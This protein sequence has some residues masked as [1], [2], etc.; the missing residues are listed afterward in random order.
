M[1]SQR[2]LE[3]FSAVSSTFTNCGPFE[4]LENPGSYL[5]RD[6]LQCRTMTMSTSDFNSKSLQPHTHTLLPLR[7]RY[8]GH[9]HG[10]SF[11]MMPRQP[12]ASREATGPKPQS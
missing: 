4:P 3:G 12:S 9:L 8:I 1:L 7:D 5:V 10:H 11:P 6:T 2:V